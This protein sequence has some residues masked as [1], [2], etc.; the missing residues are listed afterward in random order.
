MKTTFYTLLFMAVTFLQ[1]QQP[2]LVKDINP[3][4]NTGVYSFYYSIPGPHAE[5]NGKLIFPGIT[6]EN[7]REL[8]ISDGTEAGTLMIKDIYPGTES[9]RPQSLMEMEGMVYFNA[10]NETG[11]RLYKT[12]GTPEGTS[13]IHPDL[14]VSQFMN[15]GFL[16]GKIYIHGELADETQEGLWVSDGTE[17]GT[18]FIG[19]YNIQNFAVLN[20]KML[21][22][23]FNTEGFSLWATDG[24]AAGTE[25]IKPG[26]NLYETPKLVSGGKLYFTF[27]DITY[28][29]EPWVT[30][31]TTDG[32]F[33]LK[34]IYPGE[35]YGL[36]GKFIEYNGEVY[37]SGGITESLWKTDGTETGTIE[38]NPNYTY[39]QIVYNGKLLTSHRENS[40]TGKELYAFDGTGFEL[41][42]DINP[43]GSARLQNFVGVNGKTWFY[44]S[45]HEEDNETSHLWVTDGTEAGT[46]KIV[47]DGSTEEEPLGED[48]GF[49]P[50]GNTLYFSA[51]YFPEYGNE[52]YKLDTEA[53]SVED[54]VN[55]QK[56]KIYPN[57]V[58][59]L[60]N[61]AFEKEGN[62]EYSL[63][64][65]AGQQVKSGEFHR[66]TNQLAVSG[67]PKGTYVL[68]ISE[69]N[70][71][72]VSTHK[73]IVK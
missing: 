26:V 8:W 31:G 9:S 68:K 51:N 73:I 33:M 18:Q 46:M 38:V 54:V 63:Y 5:L 59:D 16:N 25:M 32:T 22:S 13:P 67:L 2:V 19:D 11:W 39:P 4:E 60:L 12:D 20:D 55:N 7:G 64:S 17:A 52:L 53:L 58:K 28:G 48:G 66:K 21:F 14:Q 47:P 69:K 45:W 3:G 49:F 65:L 61:I 24:T 50:I 37:F 15:P 56:V 35:E 62:H 72:S 34:D 29:A 23:I 10:E 41:V 6:E 57:P 36:F 42:K 30:D 40:E 1:G 44:G 71:K 43:D 70:G 27:I